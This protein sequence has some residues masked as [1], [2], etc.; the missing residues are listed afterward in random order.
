MTFIDDL[1]L[2][3]EQREKEYRIEMSRLRADQVLM[4]LAV[5][6]EK[7]ADV[8]ELVEAETKILQDYQQAE[9]Q[10]LQK[11]MSWLEYNLDH[12]IRS[13]GE[14][15]INLAHGS[16]KLRLGRDKVEIVDLEKLLPIATRNGLLKE[17]PASTVP[18]LEKLKIYIRNNRTIPAGV[19]MT[20]AQTKFSYKTL[21]GMKHA[22]P[23]E[24]GIEAE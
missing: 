15:T 12:Y 19:T 2:E 17:I 22:E 20:P 1:L 4:A 18:D 21:K 13:T 7:V 16:I 9:L 24:V 5:L 11:K 23:A 8:N 14:K 6:E 10:K 3:S